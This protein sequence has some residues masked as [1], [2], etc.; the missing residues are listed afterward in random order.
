MSQIPAYNLSAISVENAGILQIDLYKLGDIKQ[1]E[2]LREGL[3]CVLKKYVS[4]ARFWATAESQAIMP[5]Y[6]SGETLPLPA[7]P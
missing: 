7:R 5:G 1:T 2:A 4:N 6:G 3:E